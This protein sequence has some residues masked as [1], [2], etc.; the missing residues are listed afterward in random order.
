MSDE[1]PAKPK[2]PR[3]KGDELIKLLDESGLLFEI[4]RTVL[5]PRGL[6]MYITLEDDGTPSKTDSIGLLDWR[7]D[8]EGVIFG[9]D[10]FAHCK[11][12]LRAYDAAQTQTLRD[13]VRQNKF[14]FI[15]QD[16]E[17]VPE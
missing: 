17:D 3:I 15:V 4:N 12:K 11:E 14:R 9:K 8:P 10:V 1:T 7:D 6:A 5:H 13:T 16:K 2:T